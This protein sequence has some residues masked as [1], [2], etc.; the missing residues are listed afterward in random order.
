VDSLLPLAE[1]I[2]AALVLRGETLAVAET[3]SGGLLCAALLAVPGAS[4]YFRGGAVP[5]TREARRAVMQIP[6]DA[7]R[8]LRSSSE[9]YALLLARTLRENLGATWGLSETGAAGPG[10]NIYGDAA[11]HSCIAVAGPV[12]AVITLETG[13]A[14]RRANMRAFGLAALELLARN[15]AARSA[16]GRG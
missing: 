16:S 10:G 8:G 11:G 5:Y 4:K 3:S 6:D 14:D 2:A 9:P 1:K 7:M 15:I 12:E 13:N